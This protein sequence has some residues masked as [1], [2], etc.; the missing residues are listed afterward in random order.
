MIDICVARTRERT[1][2]CSSPAHRR[3][4]ALYTACFMHIDDTGNTSLDA[5]GQFG[6]R[7]VRGEPQL[8]APLQSLAAL[9]REAYELWPPLG[10]DMIVAS[11]VE[12]VRAMHIEF[13]MRDMVPIS[14]ATRWPDYLRAKTGV[15]A[16]YAYCM[17]MKS[18]RDALE[19]NLSVMP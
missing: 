8:L 16:G 4:V 1:Y 11:T 18:K 3:F 9:L 7:L 14:L 2:G 13:T 12:G 6:A 19:S 17:F 10:A 5:V 15:C